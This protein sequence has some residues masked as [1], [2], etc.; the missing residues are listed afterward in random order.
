MFRLSRIITFTLLLILLTACQQSPEAIPTLTPTQAPSIPTETILPSPTEAPASVQPTAT[1]VSTQIESS[2]G[3]LSGLSF[4]DF[5]VE[6]FDMLLLRN[7]ELVTEMGLTSH[8]GLSEDRLTDHSD[9]YIQETY[10]IARGIFDQL[11]SYPRDTLTSDQQV[12]YDA[13]HW[14]LSDFIQGEE[15]RFFEYPITHFITGDQYELLYF[16]TDIHPIKSTEN[17][18]GYLSRL[19]QVAARI[20]QII[21]KLETQREMGIVTPRFILEWSLRDI[22]GITNSLPNLTPYFRTLETKS[23]QLE[24]ETNQRN[25]YL[26]EA[27][28]IIGASIIPAYGRLLTTMNNQIPIAPTD[29]GVWQFDG[30][31][32][33]YEY[34]LSHH[35]T[36]D[37]SAEEVHQIGLDELDRI[38]AEIRSIFKELGY[39]E[40]ES[41]VESYQRVIEESG[42]IQGQAAVNYYQELLDD[43]ESIYQEAFDLSPQAELTIIGGPTGNYYIPG[44]IDGSRPGAFYANTNSRQ[45]NFTLP[46]IGY[47]EGVP[48]HHFQIS[49]TQELEHLPPFQRGTWFTAYAEGWALYAE[50]LM[51]E[52]G[53]YDDDPYGNLGRLQWEAFRAARLVVDTGIHAM[54]WTFDEAVDFMSENTGQTEQQVTFEVSRYIA[55]PGQATSYKIGMLKILELRSEAESELGQAFSLAEF[56]NAVLRNGSL[57]LDTLGI[58]VNDYMLTDTD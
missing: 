23:S 32:D 18:E 21:T 13:Y 48:G 2:T 37:L 22:Q 55:W 12:T 52:L 3:H 6:S 41:L 54:G 16:F 34:T 19:D 24:L 29:D 45:Q 25:N 49:I 8:Y 42:T 17:I 28:Q 36:T 30:G 51:W 4:D 27:Q 5:I 9:A 35:T 58:V 15:F 38:H 46:T 33:Y 26:E 43:A 40:S 56:H 1:I 10:Q 50:Q 7:P 47:H 39:P 53:A 44:A 31:L 20:D 11:E 57:P 14:Y